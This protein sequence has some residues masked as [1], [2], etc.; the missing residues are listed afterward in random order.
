MLHKDVLLRVMRNSIYLGN[1]LFDKA[2][3][4]LRSQL[5]GGWQLAP[6]KV[7]EVRELPANALLDIRSP[8]GASAVL[9]VEVKQKVSPRQ[10]VEA[11]ARLVDAAREVRVDGTLLVS[12]YLSELSRKRLRKAGVN[13]FDLTGNIWINLER[14]GL[15]IDTHGANQDP[16]PPRRAVQSLKGAKAARIV[17]ALC[18]TRPP[19]GVRELARF[20]KSNPGYV[21]RVLDLLGSEDLIQRGETGQVARTNWQDLIYRWSQ[22]YS[23]TNT[24]RS[25]SWLAPR[26][27]EIVADRLRSYKRPYALTGSLAIPPEASV[28]VGRMLTCYVD[29]MEQ[30]AEILEVRSADTGANVLLIEPFDSVVY[31]RVRKEDTLIKVALSQCAVD[32]LTG[33]G[34]GPTEADALISWMTANEDDWRA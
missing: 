13:Y 26:G 15:L 1:I 10:A 14:P 20:T 16:S 28:A 19:I 32:L 17:R 8:D 25:L 24:H 4:I 11:V 2:V 12:E 9:L 23:L 30:A 6:R 22:D 27:L 33:G 5:S 18:D 29:D 34:R 21:S 31:D 3:E 7:S